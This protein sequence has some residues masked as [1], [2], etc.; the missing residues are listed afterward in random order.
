[1]LA[2][3]RLVVS[4]V[5]KYVT[6]PCSFDDLLSDGIQRLIRV[7]DKFDF[8]RGFRFSTYAYRALSR[9]AY[10][11]VV[12]RKQE[13]DKTIGDPDL[14]DALAGKDDAMS[15][16][17]EHRWQQLREM[18]AQFVDRLDRRERFIIRSRYALGSH[19]TTRTL[20]YLAGRLG[21]SKERVRQLEQR[22]VAKMQEM[23]RDRNLTDL[24]GGAV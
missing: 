2:N 17:D 15:S 16:V 11:A 21:L 19:R 7:V 13:Q 22:A 8:E 5:K 20:Q 6:P 3:I 24:A 10:R 12:M 18:L 4:L 1:M 23:A 9:E 14:V